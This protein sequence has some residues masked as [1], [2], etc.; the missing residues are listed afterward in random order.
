MTDVR[1]ATESFL[2][3]TPDGDETL[4][5]L[6][7]VDAEHETW[8]F[9]DIPIGSGRF[10]ELVSR[11]I[12]EAQGD[13]YRVRDR[14]AVVRAL[15]GSDNTDERTRQAVSGSVSR[16]LGQAD[17]VATAGVVGALALVVL[18]RVFPVQS[19]FQ[20]GAIVLSGNDPYY[21][22]YLVEQLL[23]E[24]SSAFDLLSVVSS[25]PSE[26]AHGEP[27]FVSTLWVVSALFGD[28]AGVLAWYPV[29]S[30]LVTGVLVYLLAV[31]VTADKRVGIAAVALLS[32]IPAHA[33]RTG[34]GFAD[35]HAF[36]YPWLALT[37][38]AL[39][40][41]V[42]QES[43]DRSTWVWALV[44][45]LGVG[46]QTLA[47]DAGPL[48][49][50]PVALVVVAVGLS[51]LR[52]GRAPII[53]G[54][55]ISVGLT[56]GAVLTGGAHLF[57]GWHSVAVASVPPLLLTGTVGVYTLGEIAHRR[58]LSTR[59]VAGIEL[60]VATIGLLTIQVGAPALVTQFRSGLDF[61]LTTDGIAETTS[62]VSGASGSIAAPMLLFG[63]ALFLA[64]PYLGWASWLSYRRHSPAWVVG[65]LYG[66]Y[67]LVLSLLQIRFAGHLALATALFGGLGF[68]HVAAW[69]D[70]TTYPHPFRSEMSTRKTHTAD[71]EPTT[72]QPELESPSRRNALYTAG[73]GLGVGSLG[74]L[75]TPIKHRQIATDSSMYHTAQF[76][77][78]YADD[79][80]WE[81]P[82]NY[83]FSNWGKNRMYN[84]FVNGESE[85]YGFAADKFNAFATSTDSEKWYERLRD[86]VGFVVINDQY[87]RETDR[88]TNYDRLQADTFGV[89]TG[90]FQAVWAAEDNGVIVYRL[91]PGARLTGETER[92][93]LAIDCE[94]TINGQ[95]RSISF[96]RSVPDS[97][98][99]IR[100]PLPGRYTIR[101]NTIPVSESDVRTG[102]QI[103]TS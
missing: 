53:T 82:E 11:D 21:Y 44:L 20:Q 26:I 57:F 4:E 50:V 25:L 102:A 69:V 63:L 84:W 22:Q 87:R 64:L 1:A 99:D 23:A 13:A 85:S 29:V 76:M 52:A 48:L 2:A 42:E 24:S 90:H 33:F 34:L 31:R 27:L 89:E 75:L 30:A 73:L 92:E 38:L 19:V 91:V 78:A 101:G 59:T 66:W 103:Q 39:V 61:L 45:G 83:V 28:A 49:L 74:M 62:L 88:Q 67:F 93:R 46:G 15:E 77:R 17:T 5:E 51:E 7:A 70:I 95:D 58:E 68:V 81:Y 98:Y 43:W 16:T 60:V 47:W 96:D 37:A 14:E 36:D 10:G 97:T 80:G 79:R 55:P 94:C 32:I 40:T 100:V 35:H 71:T 54:V 9:E 86:R 41:L 72:G 65:C 18:F 56:A 3:E 6:L 8:T 12:V